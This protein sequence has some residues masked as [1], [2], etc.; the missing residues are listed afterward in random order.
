MVIHS[1]AHDKR[2]HK[3]LERE[4]ERSQRDIKLLKKQLEKQ[5][6]ACQ[7]DA[8]TVAETEM[9][10]RTSLHHINI[11]VSE[12]HRY[13]GGRPKK[14]VPRVPI[15]TR[16]ILVVSIIEDEDALEKKRKV[17][18]CFVL[19]TNIPDDIYSAEKIICTS[20]IS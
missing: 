2:R 13:A 11:D 15:E 17:A 3:R 8:Q 6:F 5:S 10:N 18:G 16:Y 19:L 7:K 12:K 1:S 20:F 4:I 14:G 9:K